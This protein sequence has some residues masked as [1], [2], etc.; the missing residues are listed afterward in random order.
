MLSQGG[1]SPNSRI[2][3]YVQFGDE[4]YS[5]IVQNTQWQEWHQAKI[6]GIYT[7]RNEGR[8]VKIGVK[9]FSDANGWGMI[10]DFS[11][12]RIE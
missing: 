9:I 8:S 7:Y 5:D 4:Y 6:D 1:D 10:D 11:L 2:M 3:L 12:V